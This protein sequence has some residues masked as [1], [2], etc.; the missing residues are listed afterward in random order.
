MI[1]ALADWIVDES[2]WLTV[3][4]G[5]AVLATVLLLIGR[6]ASGVAR[7]RVTMAALNLFFGV[8]IGTMAL[9]HLLAVS[10]KLVVGSLAGSVLLFYAIGLALAVPSWGV[11]YHTRAILAH[12]EPRGATLA[13]NAWLAVTLVALGTPNLP[14]AVPGLL[15]V[16]YGA[17]TSPRVGRLIVAA[18]VVLG[19]G[20]FL[21]SLRFFVSGQTFEQLRGMP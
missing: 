1:A 15:N 7:R 19:I 8:T 10:T 17:H 12:P 9:G 13:L 18:F 2:K 6:R 14:L 20:L 5:C 4:I 3:S 11:V 16:A 21:G